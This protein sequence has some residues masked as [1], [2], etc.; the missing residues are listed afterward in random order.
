MGASSKRSASAGKPIRKNKISIK[1]IA[2]LASVSVGTV[3]NVLN[4]KIPV[5]PATEARVLDAIKTT[6]YAPSPAAVALRKG[7]SNLVGVI[8]L[9]IS[10][11]FFM[12]AAA[13]MDATLSTNDCFAALASTCSDEDREREIIRSFINI[14]VRSILLT[15]TGQ[16][17]SAAYE[18]VDAGVP[19]VLFD[20]TLNPEKLSSVSV[21]DKSGA[22]IA[23]NHLLDLGHRKILFLNGPSKLQQSVSRLS[24]VKEA[25]KEYSQKIDLETI[26][27][28][29]FAA[30]AAREAMNKYLDEIMGKKRDAKKIEALATAIFCAN[31]LMACGALSSLQSH[32]IKVPQ[33]VS[34]IGFDDIA[35]ASQTSVPLTTISQDMETL[36]AQSAKLALDKNDERK[37]IQITPELVVRESTCPPR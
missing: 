30:P 15:P 28:D 6:G 17:L 25:C 31:D 36:G 16:D 35:I 5:A 29:A 10:N 21:D 3:S 32:G 2:E 18:A 8:V 33:D 14:G 19:V 13:G 1:D 26:E 24:G 11:P 20:S 22:K 37:H 7:V 9:D 12:E 27:I 34:L 23:I 4:G